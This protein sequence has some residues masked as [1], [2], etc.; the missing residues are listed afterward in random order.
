M[1]D[2]MKCILRIIHVVSFLLSHRRDQTDSF[3]RCSPV[4]AVFIAR[5]KA[6]RYGAVLAVPLG[7]KSIQSK[8]SSC[9]FLKEPTILKG[10]VLN[11]GLFLPTWLFLYSTSCFRQHHLCSLC[12]HKM[13]YT[14]LECHVHW[15]APCLFRCCWPVYCRKIDDSKRKPSERAVT[16]KPIRS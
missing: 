15:P 9:K 1:R 7:V 6:R 14:L 8:G 5:V 10:S 3:C 16:S 2:E 12:T 11:L 13:I 4:W